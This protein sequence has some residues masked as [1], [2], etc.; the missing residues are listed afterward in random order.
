[1]TVDT[2]LSSHR[3]RTNLRP[4][5]TPVELAEDAVLEVPAEEPARVA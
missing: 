2:A 5:P 1:M 4:V 3:T